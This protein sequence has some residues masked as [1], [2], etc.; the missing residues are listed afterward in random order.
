MVAQF[1]PAN[2][3]KSTMPGTKKITLI[4]RIALRTK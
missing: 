2:E 3:N 4:Q 1:T